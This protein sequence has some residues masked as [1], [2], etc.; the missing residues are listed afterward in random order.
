MAFLAEN[1]ENWVHQVEVL[2]QNNVFNNVFLQ[3]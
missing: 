1:Q 3:K 2:I